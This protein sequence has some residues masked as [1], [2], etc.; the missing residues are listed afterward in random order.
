MMG[1]ARAPFKAAPAWA[2]FDHM[3]DHP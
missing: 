1:R 3:T 2:R